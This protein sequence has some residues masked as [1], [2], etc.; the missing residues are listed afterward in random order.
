MLLLEVGIVVRTAA[1][2][3]FSSRA[4]RAKQ[5]HTKEGLLSIPQLCANNPK[6]ATEN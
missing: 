3:G 4:I 2:R 5:G 6:Y 1:L